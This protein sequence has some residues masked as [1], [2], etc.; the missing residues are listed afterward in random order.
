MDDAFNMDP[1]MFGSHHKVDNIVNGR[2]VLA[3][4]WGQGES[5]DQNA[6]GGMLA[7]IYATSS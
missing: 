5:G 1:N 7:H 3:T 2:P 4:L 6:S